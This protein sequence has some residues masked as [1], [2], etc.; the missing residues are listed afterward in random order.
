M[1]LYLVFGLVLVALIALV[2]VWFVMKKK[3]KAQ[4][5]AAGADDQGGGPGNEEVDALVKEAERRLG[6]SKQGSLGG[7][8]IFFLVGDIGSTKTSVVMN[9]GVEPEL[10]AGLVYRDNNMVPTRTAN[11]WFSR[12]TIF[13]EA[14]GKLLTEAAKWNRLVRKLQPRAGVAKSGQSARAVLVC[15]DAENFT[16]PGAQEAASAAART[17]G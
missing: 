15:Y 3:A 13:A 17:L 8:P 9:A 2:I 4:A 14:G 12:R 1:A 7:L 5:A 11:L 16:R 10:L 6:A